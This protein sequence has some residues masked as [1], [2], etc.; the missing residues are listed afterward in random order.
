MTT[1]V[2]LHPERLDGSA[3]V[4]FGATATSLRTSTGR[5]S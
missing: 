3:L 1:P 2:D 4:S 5:S